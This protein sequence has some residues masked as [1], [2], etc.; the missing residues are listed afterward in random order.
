MECRARGIDLYLILATRPL[1]RVGSCACM[2]CVVLL[3]RGCPWRKV[4]PVR[5]I[6]F[7]CCCCCCWLLVVVVLCECLCMHAC[8][9]VC[10][11][12]CMHVCMYACVCV[13]VCVRVC[14]CVYVCVCVSV[15]V[16]R[17][18]H[19]VAALIL[20]SLGSRTDLA[21]EVGAGTARTH[22]LTHARTHARG[23]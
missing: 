17:C 19:Q 23:R 8:M 11:Y 18:G 14:E 3:L 12:V 6:F 5:A 16:C 15:C 22:T 2:C 9:Y 13:C 20:A 1:H 7:L 4:M 10:M 21:Q